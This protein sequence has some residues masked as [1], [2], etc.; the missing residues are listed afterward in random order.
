VDDLRIQAA[1]TV[2]VSGL[3]ASVLFLV[4]SLNEPYTGQIHVSQYPFR[5]ALQQFN[6]LNLGQH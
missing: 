3:L 6:A 5:H 1:M 4:V 2:V